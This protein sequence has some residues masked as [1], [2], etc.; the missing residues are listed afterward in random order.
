[1]NKK[2]DMTDGNILKKIILFAIP[3]ILTN[4]LNGLYNTADIIIISHFAGSDAL[5]A[6]GNCTSVINISFCLFLGLALG[7]GVLVSHAVGA[8]DED[9]ISKTV[10]TAAIMGVLLGAVLMLIGIFATPFMLKWIST[11]S[12]IFEQSRLYLQIFFVGSIPNLLYTFLAAILRAL[13][14]SKKPLYY[15]IIS[16]IVKI[17][18]NIVLVAH[19]QLDIFGVGIA[20]VAAQLVSAAFAVY[21]FMHTKER[22]RVEIKRLRVTRDVAI[23]ILKLGLPIGITSAM[24]DMANLILSS[25]V[26]SFDNVYIIA[27]STVEVQLDQ[28]LPFFVN[29]MVSGILTFAGQNM[30]AKKYDRVIRGTNYATVFCGGIVL[31]ASFGLIFFAEP[32]ML[33]F[34]DDPTVIEWARRKQI[35]TLGLYVLF[36]VY[37]CLSAAIKGCGNT[38]LPMIISVL[39]IC[40]SRILWLKI[41]IPVFNS[42][43]TVYM[44]YPMSYILAVSSTY[45]VYRFCRKL[46]LCKYEE[47]PEC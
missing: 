19:F 8:C 45:V 25:Y 23:G 22:H 14:N 43:E 6:V 15:L 39:S 28:Y 10:H 32:L 26:N 29:G 47:S 24:F 27:G 42:I 30:G 7:G 34:N 18:L 1:M 46:W 12:D 21:E 40:V 9:K 37:E 4:I 13:G 16:C 5:A 44:A 33:F 20:T 31:L 41:M 17:I 11:P 35:L 3:V 2:T 38:R 36:A